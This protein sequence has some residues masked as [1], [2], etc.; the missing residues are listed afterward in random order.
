MRRVYCVWATILAATLAGANTAP[1]QSPSNAPDTMQPLKK[2]YTRAPQFRLPF[3]LEEPERVRM[4]DVQLCVRSGD[5]PGAKR[6][7]AG[8]ASTL[9]SFRAPRDGEYWFPVVIVEKRGNSVPADVTRQPP[10][11]VVV[12][13]TVSPE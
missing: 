11:L 7:P 10:G 13:D 4:G 12:V 1:A 2:I 9:F 3:N 5:D 6:E 8:P